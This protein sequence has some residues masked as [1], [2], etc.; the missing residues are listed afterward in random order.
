MPG[1]VFGGSRISSGLGRSTPSPVLLEAGWLKME[2]RRRPCSST[3]RCLSLAGSSGATRPAYRTRWPRACLQVTGDFSGCVE[4]PRGPEG[5]SGDR[6][7]LSGCSQSRAGRAR[8]EHKKSP[9][10]RRGPLTRIWFVFCIT[11]VRR[12][13]PAGP[14]DPAADRTRRAVPQPGS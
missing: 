1:L 4:D 12:S 2:P 3:A 5:C 8:N 11:E 10:D 9:A 7:R 13:R 14:S 6:L